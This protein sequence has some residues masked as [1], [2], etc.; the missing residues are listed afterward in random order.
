MRLLLAEDD[1]M[2]GDSVRKG[3]RLD[4]LTVDWVRDGIAAQLALGSGLYQ[5]MLLDLG[6]PKMA[7]LEVL[8]AMR[9]TGNRIPVLILTARDAVADRVAGLDAG[10]DD[11]LVKP[12]DLEEL[13]ARIRALLRRQAGRAAPEIR[14]GN[15][16]LNP[17]THEVRLHDQQVNLS[18]REFALLHAF[19]DRP[20]TVFS[21][22]QLEEKLYGWN[23]EVESNTV[24][25]YIH[26]LRK[27]LGAELIKNV[28][29]VG[30]MVPIPR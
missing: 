25:V 26:A 17:A 20:G 24:E 27:K 4:G 22:A 12:F 5:L 13:A 29:G 3:L 6:L 1:T 10:A 21:R 14:L 19:L 11:Y 30:Y 28:R 18:A 7:G 2:I 15:L 23:E 9:R 8:K 16:S